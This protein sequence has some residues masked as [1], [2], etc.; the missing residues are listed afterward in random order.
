MGI[1][2]IIK[3][4]HQPGAPE[5]RRPEAIARMLKKGTV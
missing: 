5:K 3:L 4:I 2:S 1:A